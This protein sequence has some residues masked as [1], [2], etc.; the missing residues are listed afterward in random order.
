MIKLA[1]LH[2][3]AVRGQR[4]LTHTHLRA[5]PLQRDQLT[6]VE[7]RGEGEHVRKVGVGVH[8]GAE[9]LPGITAT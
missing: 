2:V 9:R 4:S 7:H 1:T 5:L 3:F 6:L 8:E